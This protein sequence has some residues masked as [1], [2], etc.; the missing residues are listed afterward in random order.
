MATKTLVTGLL[1]IVASFVTAVDRTRVTTMTIVEPD[2]SSFTTVAVSPAMLPRFQNSTDVPNSTVT[3]PA[4][5][6]VTSADDSPTGQ[7]PYVQLPAGLPLGCWIE[8]STPGRALPDLET[9]SQSMTVEFC[10]DFCK[11][12][13]LFGVEYGIE[14]YCANDIIPGRAFPVDVSHCNV[15]CA[16]NS[17]EDCG[18]SGAL[19]IYQTLPPLPPLPS[20]M[21]VNMTYSD[22]GCYS[23]PTD[24]SRALNGYLTSSDSAMSSEYCARICGLS[25]FSFFALEFSSEC[26]CDNVVSPLAAPIDPSSCSMACT[27]NAS[28]TC[29]GTLAFELFNGTLKSTPLAERLYT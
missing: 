14:C 15:P 18:G 29:G 8:G 7:D 25:G 13:T 1:A 2:P 24:G 27:G 4:T 28:E 10:A 11:D 22:A 3:L 21:V 20:G 23:E 19:Y 9:S 17:D 6:I 26:W 5:A 16:G 12:Y